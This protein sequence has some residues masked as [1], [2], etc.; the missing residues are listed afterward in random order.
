MACGHR[1]SP[2]AVVNISPE[3]ECLLTHTERS[4]WMVQSLRAYVLGV[5]RR[6]P[7]ALLRKKWL[8]P[9]THGSLFRIR[10]QVVDLADEMSL[11]N[12]TSRVWVKK[13]DHFWRKAAK[14]AEMG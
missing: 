4:F 14:E 10:Q 12:V 6:P 11:G 3:R 2:T 1:S 7:D 8:H 13:P 9:R 5:M